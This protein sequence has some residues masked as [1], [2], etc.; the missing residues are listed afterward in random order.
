MFARTQLTGVLLAIGVVSISFM[1]TAATEKQP[2]Q[3]GQTAPGLSLI[4]QTNG[5]TTLKQYNEKKSV[6]LVFTRAHW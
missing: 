2:A 4:N 6:V 3:K 5:V 1:A